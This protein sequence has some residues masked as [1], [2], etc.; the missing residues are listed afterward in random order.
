MELVERSPPVGWNA[1]VHPGPMD[2]VDLP[3][4]A[5]ASLEVTYHGKESHASMAPHLGLNGL[6]ALNIS[7]VAISALR[8]H[9]RQT[10]RITASSRMEAMPPT[11]SR[12]GPRLP[13][14]VWAAN[15][16]ELQLLTERVVRCFEAGGPGHQV[17]PGSEVAG[18]RTTSS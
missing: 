2:V 12:T 3:T 17:R 9:I 5:W 10:E 4:P 7:Y 18:R 16:E 15:S 13:T 8:Q 11:S 6:D 14:F 1:V